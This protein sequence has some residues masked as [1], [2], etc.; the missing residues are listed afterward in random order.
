MTYKNGKWVWEKI[1]G[2]I[3]NEA[4]D[5]RNYA[6]AAFAVMKPNMDVLYQRLNGLYQR[7]AEKTKKKQQH[8]RNVY[9]DDW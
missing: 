5:C 3:R 6:N 9:E 8:R 2:H 7:G 4:L 1:P